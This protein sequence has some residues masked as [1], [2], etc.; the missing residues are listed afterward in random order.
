[1]ASNASYPDVRSMAF[2][3][4]IVLSLFIIYEYHVVFTRSWQHGAH[5]DET[6]RLGVAMRRELLFARRDDVLSFM[7]NIGYIFIVRRL[8]KQSKLMCPYQILSLTQSGLNLR[9]LAH[10]AQ[11]LTQEPIRKPPSISSL[12]PTHSRP[13]N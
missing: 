13:I 12:S 1:M 7:K 6:L 8:G 9:I 4:F 3:R 5:L 10:M 11:M 2:S